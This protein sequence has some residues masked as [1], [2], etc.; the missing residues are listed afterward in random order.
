VGGV[1][2][3]VAHV[4]GVKETISFPDDF[5]KM[6]V[7]TK[8]MMFKLDRSTKNAMMLLPSDCRS[9]SFWHPALR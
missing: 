3:I 7:K 4:S 1:F 5:T 9:S 2:A 8:S 6:Q